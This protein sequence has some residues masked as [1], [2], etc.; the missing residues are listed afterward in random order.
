M[1]SG[2]DDLAATFVAHLDLLTRRTAQALEE[3]GFSSLLAHSGAPPLWFKDDQHYP[4][5]VN[6][7]FKLWAPITDVADCFLYFE[8]G[9]K[10]V[11]LFHKPQD[12][13]HKPADLPHA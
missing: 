5:K 3:A 4:F 13:W 10:P 7:L 1:L 9:K 6:A 8:P 11:L 2:A 12:Y